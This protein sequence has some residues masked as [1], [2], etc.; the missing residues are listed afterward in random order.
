MPEIP[1]KGPKSGGRQTF[2]DQSPTLGLA[3]PTD[4]A[5]ECIT[6][7]FLSR[8][9]AETPPKLSRKIGDLKLT[10]T[11]T[12]RQKRSQNL[13]P[14]LVIISGNSLVFSR[15]ITTSTCFYRCCAPGASA[16]VVVK[17]QSPKKSEFFPERFWKISQGWIPK[18]QFWYPLLRFGSQHRIPK[19]QFF[20][21]FWVSTADFGFS[22]RRRKFS[23]FFPEVPVTKIRVSAPAPYKNPTVSGTQDGKGGCGGWIGNPD[24]RCDMEFATSCPPLSAA[25]FPFSL[26]SFFPF[27]PCSN[28]LCRWDANVSA[29]ATMEWNQRGLKGTNSKGQTEPNPHLFGRFSLIFA[30]FRISWEVQHFGGADFRRKPQTFAETRRKL[31]IFAEISRTL[32][33]T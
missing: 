14:V 8:A 15:K 9:G 20:L 26:P 16:R 12:E 2:L 27:L 1:W 5:R 10:S 30:D 23:D 3:L 32:K 25:C 18:P 7:G 31:Q 22:A 29:E 28:F 33:S 6:A 19:R 11:S 21:V 13:A 24:W 4:G 17:N